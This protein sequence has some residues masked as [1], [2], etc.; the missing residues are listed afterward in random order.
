M[1]QLPFTPEG[2]QQKQEELYRLSDPELLTQARQLNTDLQSWVEANFI[3]NPAQKNYLSGVPE[4]IKFTWGA[5]IAAA[6]VNRGT[7]TMDPLPDYKSDGSASAGNTNSNS[8]NGDDDP[9]TG[10]T[11]EIKVEDKG[12]TNY[13]PEDALRATSEQQPA[14]AGGHRVTIKWRLL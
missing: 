9:P 2:V 12:E 14:S 8:E 3:L 5:Q 7:I 4:S 10:R 1:A 13:Q 11:K 6:I